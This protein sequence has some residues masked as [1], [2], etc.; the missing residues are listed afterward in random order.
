MRDSVSGRPS[1]LVSFSRSQIASIAATIIDFGGL[2]F[3]TEIVGIWYVASTALGA[4]LGATTHFLLGRYWCFEATHDRVHGQAGRYAVVST[5]SLLLN[6]A[7]V[8]ALTEFGH[9][10]YPVS[11]AIISFLVGIFFNFPLHRRYVF[12]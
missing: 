3:F 10:K 8:Y 6:S 7:G 5:L 2:I 12:R 11:K 9:F 4:A 1:F